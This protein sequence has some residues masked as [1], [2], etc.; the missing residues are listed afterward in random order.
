MHSLCL[1]RLIFLPHTDCCCWDGDHAGLLR[2]K[3]DLEMDREEIN[4]DGRTNNKIYAQGAPKGKPQ[5]ERPCT[6]VAKLP[7]NR[8]D[9]DI[10]ELHSSINIIP[11]YALWY[12]IMLR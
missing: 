6:A 5:R 1:F 10:L 9:E 11:Y 7:V 2:D 12:F 8:D 4:D 3:N